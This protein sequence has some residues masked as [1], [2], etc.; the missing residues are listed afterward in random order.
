VTARLHLALGDR[1]Y[2]LRVGAGAIGKI[3]AFLGKPGRAFLI[4]D[5]RLRGARARTRASLTRAGWRVEELP[6]AAGERLKDFRA[7]YPLYGELLKRGA[8]RSATLFALGGGSVGD[9]AGFV[10]ATYLRG[11][12]WVG[13]PTTL[14]AQ[15]DSSVGG[16][17]GINH[18]AGKNLIGAF[19]QPSLVVCDT[20]FLSTLSARERVS[21]LGEI[22]KIGASLDAR[23]LAY[24]RAN[25]ERLLRREPGPTARAI[26][27]ALAWKCRLV[28]RDELDR[29]GVREV[30]N[31]GHTFGHALEA[32]TG[33][34]RYQHGEAVLWG[35]RFAVALSEVRGHLRDGSALDEFLSRLEVPRLPRALSAARILSH[36]KKDKKLRDGRVRFVLIKAEGRAVL[37]HEV[38][39]RDLLHAFD[40]LLERA[41]A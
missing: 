18:A 11:I 27:S 39:E 16:K 38:R 2:D 10:A 37:D 28:S 22:V 41:H 29:S 36:M 1:S 32:E 24:L 17:T 25:L 33:F 26:Q 34:H 21:G 15:V 23:L 30:L 8:D 12:R 5:E 4:S 31:F 14:L 7:V 40:K 3:G 9:A 19:H 20:D 35:M 13:L 6:V